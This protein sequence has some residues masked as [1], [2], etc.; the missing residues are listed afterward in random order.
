MLYYSV[1]KAT[2]SEAL[3]RFGHA[4]SDPNRVSIL[5]ALQ[6]GPRYPVDLVEQ[7]GVSKQ[8]LSNHLTCLRGCGLV[9]VTPEGRRTRY[10]LSDIKLAHALDDV[11]GVV[12]MVDPE[13]CDNETN[14]EMK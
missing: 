14:G 3:A 12:L 6:K 1:M 2:S 11:L 8:N 9:T 13:Y 10:A 4:L 7:L 5:L